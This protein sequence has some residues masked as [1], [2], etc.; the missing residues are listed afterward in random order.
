MKNIG[1]NI[2]TSKDLSS[3]ILNNIK[4]TIFNTIKDAELLF[5]KDAIG[6]KNADIKLDLVISLGGD[7]TMLRVARELATKGTPI[8]GVNIGNLG[9]LTEVESTEFPNAIKALY[10][11]N[12]F[13]ESRMMLAC[14]ITNKYEKKH[15]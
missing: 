12:F 2:N 6:L 15:S 7:G 13:I 9:F 14:N 5:F 1:I 10:E 11:G 3:K 4:K 8:F